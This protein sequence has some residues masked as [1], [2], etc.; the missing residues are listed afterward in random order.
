MSPYR[1]TYRFSVHELPEGPTPPDM[2]PEANDFEPPGPE[3]TLHGWE[4]A[5]QRRAVVLWCKCEV[6]EDSGA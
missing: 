6:E 5:T 3:W 1:C 4:L 2:L